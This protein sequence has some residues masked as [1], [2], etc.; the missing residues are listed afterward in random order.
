MS[1]FSNAIAAARAD[2]YLPPLSVTSAPRVISSWTV[3]G[4]LAH[5]RRE[6]AIVS[7]FTIV[8][9]FEERLSRNIGGQSTRLQ[10]VLVDSTLGDVYGHS[11]NV[12]GHSLNV[13]GHSIP[14]TSGI[15]TN[16]LFLNLLTWAR[17]KYIDPRYKNRVSVDIKRVSVDITR[18]SVDVTASA[19]DTPARHVEAR[20]QVLAHLRPERIC[21]APASRRNLFG[22]C[23]R[24]LPLRRIVAAQRLR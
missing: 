9:A 16:A 17:T 10:L 2:P 15:F 12:Y 3:V 24:P 18:V 22:G 14:C 19:P 11:R 1:S 13:Y 4:N 23:R 20:L 6:C 5:N 7:R 21:A 8:G